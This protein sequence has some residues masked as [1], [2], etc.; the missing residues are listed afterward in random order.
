MVKTDKIHSF[1]ISLGL[2]Q[3]NTSLAN[4]RQEQLLVKQALWPSAVASNRRAVAFKD[5]RRK[6]TIASGHG[7]AE[8]NEQEQY[9]VHVTKARAQELHHDQYIARARQDFECSTLVTEKFVLIVHCP[10]IGKLKEHNTPHTSGKSVGTTAGATGKEKARFI[11]TMITMLQMKMLATSMA[12][13]YNGRCV[14]NLP[15]GDALSCA[16]VILFP[17]AKD[18]CLFSLSVTSQWE[19][20]LTNPDPNYK[21]THILKDQGYVR[22]L[23]A[24]LHPHHLPVIQCVL[25]KGKSWGAPGGYGIVGPAFSEAIAVAKMID[26]GR[27]KSRSIQTRD[28]PRERLEYICCDNAM[29]DITAS[30]WFKD[31]GHA[32]QYQKKEQ[33]EL[34]RMGVPHYL[35]VSD[36]NPMLDSE[37]CEQ[38]R[39]KNKD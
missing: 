18:A 10:N 37:H 2:K 14:Q 28:R 17:T 12:S 35:I 33:A 27:V 5:K 16:I 15:M 9:N 3:C 36:V 11:P 31:K 29:H 21:V 6:S 38:A 24:Q 4:N 25:S 23:V 19:A 20:L 32:I 30:T 1:F 34:E 39:G 7:T 8:L 13:D 22:S 26:K